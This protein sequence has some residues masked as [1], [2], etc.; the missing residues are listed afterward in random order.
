[1]TAAS[2]K[3]KSK[4]IAA[5]KK[6]KKRIG[7]KT[8]IGVRNAAKKTSTT[9]PS[10]AARKRKTAKAIGAK[11]KPA[12]MKKAGKTHKGVLAPKRRRESKAMLKE[13]AV[14]IAQ[15]L[16]GMYP[17]AH[18]ELEH[19]SPYQLLISTI[20]SAQTTDV[21]VNKATPALFKRYP[22][23]RKLADAAQA[24]VETLVATLGFFRNKAGNIIGCA[25]SLVRDF[26]GEVPRTMERLVTLP[27]V[28]RKTAN[29][30]LGN[31]FRINVGVVVDTH[32]NRISKLLGLTAPD[33]KP[34]QI[35]K[36]L[37]ALVPQ[38][39]W[40]DFAHWIIWHG[41]RCCT[42]RA[43]E[44]GRCDVAPDCPSKAVV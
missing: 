22:T 2:K 34:P 41:R 3:K 4:A 9:K 31:A 28:A 1:M 21:A 17:D 10:R 35:E 40:T 32:V 15:T 11:P 33:A 13:R 12:K 39:Q 20:L 16:A 44:C 43:P 27:G 30:V 29:V 24:D 7:K 6:N 38:D 18:C 23:P 26:G 42:A 14:R 25:Q 19:T 37:M 8:V 36:D 5:K